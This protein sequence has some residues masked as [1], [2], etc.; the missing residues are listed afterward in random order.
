MML[1][2]GLLSGTKIALIVGIDSVGDCSK[3]VSLAVAVE[4]TEQ[5]VFAVKTAH[6]V[7]ADVCGVFQF[8]C[9]YDLDR[10]FVLACEAECIVQMCAR[11]AGGIG[12]Y[13][14]DLIAKH[15]MCRPGEKSR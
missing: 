1:T 2:R 3:S 9:F 14:E 8:S 15:L 6:G 13:R 5:F 12:D 7:I 11:Q 4:D 10:D